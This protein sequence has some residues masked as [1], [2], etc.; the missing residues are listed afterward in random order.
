MPYEFHSIS[1]VLMAD[2]LMLIV[3]G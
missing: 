2:I 3:R 1:D